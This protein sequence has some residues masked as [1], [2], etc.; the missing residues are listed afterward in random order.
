MSNIEKRIGE[1]YQHM[2]LYSLMQRINEIPTLVNKLPINYS[3]R[4]KST[5]IQTLANFLSNNG[6]FNIYQDITE[7]N[8]NS[9]IDILTQDKQYRGPDIRY[10]EPDYTDKEII[11]IDSLPPDDIDLDDIASNLVDTEIKNKV[12]ASDMKKEIII[13]PL[14]NYKPKTKKD[15]TIFYTNQMSRQQQI[16]PLEDLVAHTIS[17]QDLLN[18]YNKYCPNPISLSEL[19]SITHGDENEAKAQLINEILTAARDGYLVGTGGGFGTKKGME[20][21]Y[22][23]VINMQRDVKRVANAISPQGAEKLVKKHNELNPSSPWKLNKIDSSKPATLNNLEDE[24]QDGIPDVVIRNHRGDP[25]YV[26]GY[27]T[28]RSDYPLSLHYYTNY[29][30]KKSRTGH[31]KKQFKQQLIQARY[32]D[33]AD[34]PSMVGDV[35]SWNNPPEFENYNMKGYTIKPPERLSAY[36]RFMKY[37]IGEVKDDAFDALA[38]SQINVPSTSRLALL[39]KSAARIW[40]NDIL[41]QLYRR[42]G[43]TSDDAKKKLKKKY[44]QEID[45]VVTD[46]ISNINDLENDTRT[47]LTNRLIEEMAR[48]TRE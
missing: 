44:A 8:I 27:T 6:Y 43:A 4:F 13:N 38:D 22:K 26:N 48:I 16:N 25:V 29:P 10:E 45:D 11:D 39:S 15:N 28:K 14:I 24:N 1:L 32:I 31:S 21:L 30:T 5:N 35:E 3:P 18:I 33:A 47:N 34:D 17:V 46:M 23:I 19:E 36:Q 40:N 37:V 7:D 12:G 41:G 42:Y 20:E 9:F 2:P